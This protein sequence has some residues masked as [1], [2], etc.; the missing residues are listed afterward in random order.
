[1]SNQVQAQEHHLN[2]N[3]EGK[4]RLMLPH[5][6]V[7]HRHFSGP[8]EQA[9]LFPCATKHSTLIPVMN[10]S[11]LM[12]YKMRVISFHSS[13]HEALVCAQNSTNEPLGIF[14][15]HNRS[16]AFRGKLTKLLNSSHSL[17]LSPSR[18][19]CSN[20]GRVYLLC[21]PCTRWKNIRTLPTTPLVCCC[22]CLRTRPPRD[23]AKGKIRDKNVARQTIAQRN[24]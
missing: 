21:L 15:P 19:P 7:L 11:K 5:S 14:V 18:G 2:F 12:I 17:S 22:S 16:D 9:A 23:I 20:K 4:S 6:T 10:T 8:H 13:K 24:N 3:G 1:M